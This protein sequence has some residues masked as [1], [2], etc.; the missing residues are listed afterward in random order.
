MS[1]PAVSLFPGLAFI[2]C[3]ILK[4][5]QWRHVTTVVF[6]CL[7]KL[8]TAMPPCHPSSAVGR[9]KAWKGKAKARKTQVAGKAY[10]APCGLKLHTVVLQLCNKPPIIFSLPSLPPPSAAGLI[11]C[12][13]IGVCFI[14]S[15]RF[16]A[17]WDVRLIFHHYVLLHLHNLPNVYL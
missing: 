11:H 16:F 9:G 10:P 3:C 13:Y 7:Q 17:V 15:H 1:D 6:I 8:N 12:S 2:H 14:Q 4:C 5:Q